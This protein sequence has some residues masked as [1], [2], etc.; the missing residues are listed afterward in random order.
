MYVIHM[1]KESISDKQNDIPPIVIPPRVPFEIKDEFT[2][3][4]ALKHLR[5]KGLV[6]VPVKGQK[7]GF[8]VYDIEEAKRTALKALRD[9]QEELLKR[10]VTTQQEDRI[11][12]NKPPMPPSKTV[13]AIIEDLNVDLSAMG[14]NLAGA[15]FSIP[16]RG[17]DNEEVQQLRADL[18]ELQRNMI[19][20]MKSNNELL[21][22]VQKG[23]KA[24]AAGA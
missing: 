7:D 22:Q 20:V 11:S 23:E 13:R 19:Q 2:A 8:P 6:E 18:E 17:G 24:K 5:L 3:K 21:K 4:L 15:G 14:I 12:V 9:A 10:Y 1:G 16:T